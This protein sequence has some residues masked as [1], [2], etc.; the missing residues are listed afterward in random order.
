[1]FHDHGWTTLFL[2]DYVRW[3]TGVEYAG[4]SPFDLTYKQAYT[5][6]GKSLPQP[7]PWQVAR[8][9]MI[10]YSRIPTFLHL[11]VSEISH[12]DLNLPKVFDQELVNMFNSL[13]SAGALNETFLILMGDHGFRDTYM[14]TG[15]AKTEQGIIENNMPGLVVLP[16][17]SLARDRPGLLAALQGN[18]GVLTSQFDL[19]QL[20]REVLALSTGQSVEELF[21]G[22]GSWGPQVP[23]RGI[24]LLRPIPERSCAQAGVPLDYCSCPSGDMA[25]EAARVEGLVRAVL[26]DVDTYLEPGWGCR[27]LQDHVT[28]ISSATVRTEGPV[29]LVQALVQLTIRPVEFRVKVHFS[30]TDLSV[31][32]AGL[33]RTDR[34]EL[35]SRC[36]PRSE[37]AARPLCVCH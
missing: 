11:H 10:G 37:P 16:P 22:Q 21:P 12:D 8:D 9:F 1:M 7:N 27:R 17:A 5:Y 24:S 15:F 32:R 19:A 3:G 2:E 13:V 30:R 4:T 20:L 29:G 14:P 18:A 6:L 26:E 25:M 31:V 33:V 35:T 34:Y 28:N 23:R 36:V